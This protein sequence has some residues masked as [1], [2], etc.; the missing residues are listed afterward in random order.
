MKRQLHELTQGSP[1]W[2]EFRQN[3]DGASEAAAMLGLSKNVTRSELLKIKATGIAKEFS[4]F[5][6]ERILDHGHEVEALARPMAEDILGEELYPAT[7]SYG[8]MSASSDGLTMGGDTAF[9]HKQWAAELSAAVGRGELPDEHQPQC[10][11]IMMVTG[12]EQVLFMVSDGTPEKC[13]HMFVKPD[14]AWQARIVAGWKQFNDDRAAYQHVEAP[15]IA[16]A[17]PIRDLPALTVQIDGKV[18]ASNLA[19]WKGIVTERIDAIKTDLQTDQDFADAEKMVKFLDDGEKKIELVKQ[20]AQA[21]ATTIDEV[22]RALDE[23]KA[24]MRAKRLDLNTTVTK[25]K[26]SIRVEI[27]Q[28]GKDRLAEHIKALNERIGRPYMPVIAADFGAA[29]KGKR[30]VQSLRDAVDTLLANTKITASETADRIQINLGTLRELAADHAFLFSDTAQ[31]VLKAN[32]DLTTLVKSRIAE[33]KAAEQKKLDAERERIRAEEEAKA[34]REQE[35]KA[36]AE[37]EAKEK[38]EAAAKAAADKIEQDQKA[39]ATQESRRMGGQ[40][41]AAQSAPPAPVVAT[42]GLPSG[43]AIRTAA[44]VVPIKTTRPSDEQILAVLVAHFNVSER[45]VCEWIATFD[46][47]VAD[48]TA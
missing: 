39:T 48:A 5:V 19:E 4:D 37:A 24:T 3:H 23:I 14:P 29:I 44:N 34:R 13:V 30:T 27:A 16:T 31:I 17:T 42:H 1:E 12:A 9:E 38:Q 32:D 7:Y 21:Q 43:S 2:D 36:K 40:H 20:Q 15:P 6:Q 41:V 35:A 45:V 8:R 33:H 47:S 26:E 11:Q 46:V 28:S 22:F 18:T 25:R 10:Q